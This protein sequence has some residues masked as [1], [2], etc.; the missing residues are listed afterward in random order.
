MGVPPCLSYV[1]RRVGVLFRAAVLILI[2]PGER[3]LAAAFFHP[4]RFLSGWLSFGIR[5][6][7]FGRRLQTMIRSGGII[8]QRNIVD[9][10]VGIHLVGG[11]RCRGI[12]TGTLHGGG[13][14]KRFSK[15]LAV[16]F[17]II[18]KKT[19]TRTTDIMD[20]ARSSPILSSG[21]MR[22]TAPQKMHFVRVVQAKKVRLYV[23]KT[24]KYSLAL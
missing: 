17:I 20:I 22:T 15:K 16:V 13:D 5:S 18:R 11:F 4:R 9:I 12:R 3:R 7:P 8:R 21:N 14:G 1:V 19:W 24:G 10:A 2:F 6:P 23:C